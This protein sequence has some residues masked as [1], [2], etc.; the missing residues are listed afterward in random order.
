MKILGKMML[1]ITLMLP[2]GLPYA[3]AVEQAANHVCPVSGQE[4]MGT[5]KTVYV[6]HQGKQYALCCS[7]C[8]KDFNKDPDAYAAKANASEAAA[9][10]MG[11]SH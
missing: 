6:E 5:G 3:L 1:A 11:H 9:E 2:L 4:A 8:V 10:G 7:M